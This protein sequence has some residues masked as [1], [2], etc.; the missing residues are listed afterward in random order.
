[1]IINTWVFS[2]KRKQTKFNLMK[3]VFFFLFMLTLAGQLHAQ[4]INLGVSGGYNIS[5]VYGSQGPTYFTNSPGFNA[6]AFVDYN[7]K[8]LTAQSGLYFTEKGYN[9]YTQVATFYPDGSDYI[10]N[11]K[12]KVTLNYLEIPLNLL[13]NFHLPFGKLF[14][15]GGVYFDDPLSGNSKGTTTEVS[16]P[17][18]ATA[19]TYDDKAPIGS[20]GYEFKTYTGFEG[21]AGIRFKNRLV[22]ALKL[23]GSF[24]NFY[25]DNAESTRQDSFKSAGYSISVGYIFL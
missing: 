21:T 12:G 22:V 3:K 2:L 17:G 5:G 23:Q 11:A 24:V 13:Y 14:I 15:G 6:G 16:D 7:W 20:G 18:P 10:F 4:T 9:S 25:T 1:M 8:C 19:N